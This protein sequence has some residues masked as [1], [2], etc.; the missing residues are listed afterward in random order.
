MTPNEILKWEICGIFEERCEGVTEF[1]VTYKTSFS[2]E[3]EAIAFKNKL[4]PPLHD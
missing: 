1:I 4:M 2:T 3:A